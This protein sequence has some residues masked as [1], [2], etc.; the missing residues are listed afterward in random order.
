MTE[1]LYDR[2]GRPITIREAAAKPSDYRMVAQHWVRGWRVS[3][4]W[5]GMDAGGNPGPAPLIFETMIFPPGDETWEA[6]G[7]DDEYQERYLTEEEAHDGHDRAL[8]W[9][10]GKLGDESAADITGPLIEG[11]D[12][13]QWDGDLGGEI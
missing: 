5:L 9:L 11:S 2:Q 6:L 10:C 1:A 7:L 3:T 4:V 13:S 12:D 8:T